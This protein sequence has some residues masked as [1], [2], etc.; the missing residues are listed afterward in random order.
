VKLI[1]DGLAADPDFRARFGREVAAA[2]RVGGL[3]TALV[4]DADADG[5]TPWLATAYVVGPSL[6]DAV[7]KS[8]PLP[9]ASVLALA[10]GLAEGLAAIHAVGLVHRDL[11]PSNVLLAEDGPRVIDFGISRAAEASALTRTGSVI[12][13]PG[14]MSPEQAKGEEVGPASDMFSLGAVLVYAATGVPPFGTGST[15]ALVFRVVY[16][17]PRLD[18]VPWQVR[19]IAERCLAKDP[20]HRPTPAELLAEFGEV[21]LAAAWLPTSVLKGLAQHA[22]PASADIESPSRAMLPERV[23]QPDSP[24]APP[25]VP[26]TVTGPRYQP[27]EPPTPPT[28]PA[29]KATQPQTV[30]PGPSVTPTVDQSAAVPPSATPVAPAVARPPIRR[31]PA[32]TGTVLALLTGVGVLISQ[33][34]LLNPINLT[35]VISR[36]FSI[37]FS[38]ALPGLVVIAALVALVQIN[39]LVIIGFLQG[40]LWPGAALL[41][42]LIV[43]IVQFSNFF[44]GRIL[45]GQI[46]ETVSLALGIIAAIVL[47]ISWNPAANRRQA[48]QIRGLPLILL[49]VAGLSQI[50]VLIYY[51]KIGDLYHSDFYY[52]LGSAG[53]LATLAVTW[54]AIS[55]RQRALGGALVLGWITTVAM[56]LTIETTQNWAQLSFSG[57]LLFSVILGYVL[58]AAAVV[59]AI[60]YARKPSEW[61]ASPA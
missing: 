48:R 24:A 57:V 22:P 42:A 41:V 32:F 12:G 52:V 2:R 43:L 44:S 49:T 11:K 54:Y 59:L 9:P 6:A 19:P 26:D 25:D 4:V 46:I 33:I 56:F 30:E 37:I 27:E 34:L 23:A 31:G 55:I 1:H 16:D 50:P 35:G 39:R 13:S 58:L 40:M 36:S 3:F 20:A 8:G 15:A 61:E 29:A 5:P 38:F 17:A 45:A 21:D 14:F 51:V 18:D 28:P 7:G 60:I 10:A 53:T 47:M